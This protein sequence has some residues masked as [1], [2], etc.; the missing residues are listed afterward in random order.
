M[1]LMNQ[2]MQQNYFLNQQQQMFQ[3]HLATMTAGQFGVAF[4]QQAQV[5]FFTF[6]FILIY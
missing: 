3:H 6:F 1:M 4:Q 5:T 2:Q